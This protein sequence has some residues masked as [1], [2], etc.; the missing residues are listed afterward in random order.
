MFQVELEK[1]KSCET[2]GE[3]PSAWATSV[4]QP[5]AGSALLKSPLLF[6]WLLQTR[7][8]RR[9]NS[10]PGNREKA[11]LPACGKPCGITC[12][13][14]ARCSWPP[15]L[16]QGKGSCSCCSHEVSLRQPPLCTLMGPA[17]LCPSPGHHPSL[18]R[19]MGCTQRTCL[20]FPLIFV[21]M[22]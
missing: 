1:Q 21:L 6:L 20:A 10:A 12:S 4:A 22:C 9:Q 3:K 18:A 17:G 19:A 15:F 13:T 8:C 14:G 2:K 11:H 16:R 7:G 5:E